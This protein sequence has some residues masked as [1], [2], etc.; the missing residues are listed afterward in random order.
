MFEAFYLS[1]WQHPLLLAL[2]PVATL[3]FPPRKRGFLRSYFLVFTVGTL[4]DA[5]LTSA[6]FSFPPSLASALSLF[7]VIVGDARLFLLAERLAEPGSG[8]GW[9]LRGSL[10]AL[11]VPAAQAALLVALPD[12]FGVPRHTYLAYELLFLIFFGAYAAQR[13]RS[14]ASTPEKQRALRRLSV[15][16]LVYY[17]LWA[18]ADVVILAGFD[19]GFLLRVVPN[20]LYY[21]LFVSFACRSVEEVL[22]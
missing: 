13:A 11:A 8:R 1:V 9:F 12:I 20:F 6:L 17:G 5:F 21:G 15:Y 7:F 19:A 10:L 2:V 22:P 14:L 4:L 16:A 3:L 18:L